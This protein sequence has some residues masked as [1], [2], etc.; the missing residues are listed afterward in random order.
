M[1]SNEHGQLGIDDPVRFKNSPVLVENIDVR[2]VQMI[3]CG[4]NQ[5]FLCSED[6]EVYSWG[7][8]QFGSLGLG[9]LQD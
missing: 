2:H 3:A 4:G 6:G 1:G 9:T 7:H 5:S 8:G